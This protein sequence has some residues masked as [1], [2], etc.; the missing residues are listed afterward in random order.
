LGVADC[1]S[2]RVVD[3]VGAHELA[4]GDVVEELLGRRVLVFISD[5]NVG[6]DREIELFV[7]APPAVALVD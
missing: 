5:S 4:G 1:V 3:A 6:P 2:L 7:L